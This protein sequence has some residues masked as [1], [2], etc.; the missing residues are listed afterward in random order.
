MTLAPSRVTSGTPRP[1]RSTTV[2]TLPEA[3]E[4]RPPDAAGG[5]ADTDEPAPTVAPGVLPFDPPA[6]PS[7]PFDR[8]STMALGAGGLF[9]SLQRLPRRLFQLG[10]T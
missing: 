5:G 4:S 1:R 9:L 6:P 7:Q 8:L 10:G 3:V 2:T